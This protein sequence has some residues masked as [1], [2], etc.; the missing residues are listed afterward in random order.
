M[1]P[2]STADLVPFS[3]DPTTPHFHQCGR[4]SWGLDLQVG[5]GH[6]WQ[7]SGSI[8]KNQREYVQRHRCPE[9]SMGPFYHVL[10]QEE[11]ESAHSKA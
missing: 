4:F 9:C 11:L 3:Q 2:A 7:H 1:N 6:L 5:C 10:S 8:P